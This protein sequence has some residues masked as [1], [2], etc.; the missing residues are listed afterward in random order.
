VT[1]ASVQDGLAVVSKGLQPGEQ[2]VVDGQYR[3]TEGTRVR[4]QNATKPGAAG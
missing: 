4:L 3:L 2:I 1:V